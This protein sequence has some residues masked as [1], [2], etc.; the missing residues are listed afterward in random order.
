MADNAMTILKAIL[1]GTKRGRGLTMPRIVEV[2]EIPKSSVYRIVPT[3]RAAGLVRRL[4]LKDYIVTDKG[5]GFVLRGG[6]P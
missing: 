6:R 5:A 1:K 4:D 3:L 2:T